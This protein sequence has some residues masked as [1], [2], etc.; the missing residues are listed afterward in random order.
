MKGATVSFK[1][2][3]HR[4][5]RRSQ[6]AFQRGISSDAAAVAGGAAQGAGLLGALVAEAGQEGPA[7]G[8]MRLHPPRLH[9]QAAGP[10]PSRIPYTN[11][12]GA[13]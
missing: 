1:R 7:I 2:R 12:T 10:L 9:G 5:E 3:P 4:S 13:C 11:A 8:G 6:R